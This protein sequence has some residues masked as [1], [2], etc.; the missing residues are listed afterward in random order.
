MA[1]VIVPLDVIEV[2]GV[3]DP[4]H[5]VQLAKIVPKV[6]IVCDAP[7]IAFEVAVIDGIE[8]N[9]RGEQPPVGFRDPAIDE[10]T[11]A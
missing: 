7:H 6:W 10:I 2:D 8:A 11:L 4:R 9:E 5:L 1:A 3:D